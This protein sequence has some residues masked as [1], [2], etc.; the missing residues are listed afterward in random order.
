MERVLGIGGVFFRS[1]DPEAL[2]AWYRE[3]LG[4]P[5]EEGPY[6]MFQA[7]GQ[8]LWSPFPA[9]TD[10]FGPGGKQ[11]LLNFRVADLDAMLDQLRAA[12]VDVDD[13][14]EDS[15]HGRFGWFADPEGNRVELWQ[16][17]QR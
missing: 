14:V 9:D 7:E 12:G 17:P 11:F 8:T 6:A 2:G 4:L 15:E 10:Y 5:V 16:P 1:R 13:R 3:H